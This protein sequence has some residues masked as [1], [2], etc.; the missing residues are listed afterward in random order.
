MTLRAPQA[1]LDHDMMG[2]ALVM[3]HR[4]LGRTAP[5]PS[6]GAV[7]VDPLTSEVLARA[8][9]APGGR[10][11]AERVAIDKAGNLVRGST[12]Y[13]TLEPCSH[14][15][16][17]SPCADAVI[18]AGIERVVCG[19]E[20]P[21]PRVAGR[22]LERLRQA[23]IDVVRGFRACEARTVT[24]G[25]ICRVTQ[26]RPWVQLKLALAADGTV[27]HGQDG[28]PTFVTGPEARARGHL[29]R[30]QA[31]AILVGHGTVEADDPDLR[32]RLPGLVE[33][34]PLRVVLAR[35]GLDLSGRRLAQTMTPVLVFAASDLAP[36]ALQSMQQHGARVQ[37]AG[38]VAGQ[39]WLP[40]VLEQ[41]AARGITRLL[42]EGGPHIWQ[43]FADAGLVDE[44][45]VFVAGGVQGHAPILTSAVGW[46]HA[47]LGSLPLR[48]QDQRTLGSDT[49][50]RF[51]VA[52]H[53]PSTKAS[54]DT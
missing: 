36:S 2:I 4:G 23:G 25:H 53:T 5:N 7:L 52:A 31:D 51:S 32:C 13:V 1:Q 40:D 10:P 8:T 42:V 22:G 34:S 39:L 11:H 43:G 16:T 50:Y 24:Q 33:R 35:R 14:T 9:T 47:R 38:T 46:V 28:K 3:A 21:D 15:G 30:A 41:L 54:S 12:L 18:E 45:A 26:R 44:V 20:D 49:L 17:T 29:M 37:L 6:V 27:P 48:L 19:I